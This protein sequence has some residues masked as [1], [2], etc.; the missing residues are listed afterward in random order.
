M[1]SKE[2][3]KKDIERADSMGFTLGKEREKILNAINKIAELLGTDPNIISTVKDIEKGIKT[4][5][6]NYGR[7]M[8]LISTLSEG[9]NAYFKIAV[10]RALK[11][12]G[13]DS[14][15]VDWAMK[16]LTGRY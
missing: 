9:K 5:Q 13:A 4:T 1:N 14:Y 11:I 6:S 2:L 15:G 10:S 8:Q 12:A 3:T 7:Y 16:I